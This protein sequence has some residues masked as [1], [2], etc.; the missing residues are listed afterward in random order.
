[1][2]AVPVL[3]SWDNCDFS[4]SLSG[5]KCCLFR[6]WNWAIALCFPNGTHLLFL[7]ELLLRPGLTR[8]RGIIG[9]HLNII[10]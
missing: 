9:L 10:G 8:I 2:G 4:A 5:T 7:I 3:H 1:M 6:K